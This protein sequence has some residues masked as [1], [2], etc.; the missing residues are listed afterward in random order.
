MNDGEVGTND[1]IEEKSESRTVK[2]K[3]RK[4]LGRKA[5]QRNDKKNENRKGGEVPKTKQRILA[6]ATEEFSARGYD[7]ARVDEIM[8]RSK[9][10]KNLIY[11]FFGAKEKLFIAVLESAYEN[12]H[13][14]QSEWPNESL[15]PAEN[16]RELVRV[17]FRHWQN[18]PQFIG[19]L[20]SENFYKGR[21]I[22]KARLIKG[23]YD[24]LLKNLSVVLAQGVEEG[25]F[26]DDV[27]PVELYVSISSLA[28]HLFS[29]QHT[30]SLVLNLQ[31][32]TRAQLRVRRDHIEDLIM[33]Y[34][35]IRA[36]D[37]PLKKRDRN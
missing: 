28:Y 37:K 16:I 10:S 22:K 15:T 17:I 13:S 33:T 20:N 24:T 6:V 3:V 8:R 35:T 34:V 9:V 27:D 30:L 31:Y 7:G 12:M 29:N 36:A 1:S 25:S 23:G 32:N 11:H 14:Y 18:S 19:L 2:G 21:H 5:G 4:S 26:R